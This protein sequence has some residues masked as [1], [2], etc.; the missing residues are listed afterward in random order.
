[1]STCT[2]V[3][4]CYFEKAHWYVGDRHVRVRELAMLG[5]AYVLGTHIIIS[6]STSRHHVFPLSMVLVSYKRLTTNL[7]SGR[8]IKE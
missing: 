6:V 4:R 3:A 2:L 1:V 5:H 8:T 7:A